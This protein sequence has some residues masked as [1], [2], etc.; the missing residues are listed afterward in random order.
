MKVATVVSP[1]LP[2]GGV[3]S[4]EPQRDRALAA[5]VLR[6]PAFLARKKPLYLAGLL[7]PL[8]RKHKDCSAAAWVLGAAAELAERSPSPVPARWLEKLAAACACPGAPELAPREF[9]AE[10]PAGAWSE[11]ALLGEVLQ[12]ARRSAGRARAARGARAA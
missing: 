1:R 2:G 10:L 11:P 6:S 8:L 4:I 12:A 3:C 9:F 7:K 5:R